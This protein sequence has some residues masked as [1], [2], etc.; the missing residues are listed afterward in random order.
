MS[1]RQRAPARE[2]ASPGIAPTP[3]WQRLRG[4]ETVS[5]AHLVGRFAVGRAVDDQHLRRLFACRGELVHHIGR[6]EARVARPHFA[7][8][9]VELYGGATLQQVANL[10]DAGM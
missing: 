10:L 6:E 9:A 3:S 4:R 1:P 7:T 5:F 2:S 8:L